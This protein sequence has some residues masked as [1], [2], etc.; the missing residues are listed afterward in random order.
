M[1]ALYV[2]GVKNNIEEVKISK[3]NHSSYYHR[4]LTFDDNTQ[5][6]DIVSF[7]SFSLGWVYLST[8][9]RFV[10]RI[11]CSSEQMIDPETCS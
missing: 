5:G 4:V 1:N 9:A 3:E 2:K 7:W 6:T 10:I 8:V 11:D